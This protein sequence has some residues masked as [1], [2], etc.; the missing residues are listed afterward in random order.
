MY[1]ELQCDMGPYRTALDLLHCKCIESYSAI[2][3]HIALH[4]SYRAVHVYTCL[5][6]KHVFLVCSDETHTTF[7]LLHMSGLAVG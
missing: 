4:C 6:S 3:G 5:T 2:W 7:T 1:R